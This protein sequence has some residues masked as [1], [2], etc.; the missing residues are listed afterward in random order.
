MWRGSYRSYLF[1]PRWH[2]LR[3][4]RRAIDG[5]CCVICGRRSNLQVHHTTYRYLN[6]PGRR[7]LLLE[8]L[9]LITVCQQC[10]GVLTKVQKRKV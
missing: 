4:R 8:L 10:H 3:T 7:G 1:S 6:C 2:W 9:S 5:Q